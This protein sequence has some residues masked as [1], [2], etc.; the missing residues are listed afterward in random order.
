MPH[1]GVWSW[2]TERSA[3]Q[4]TAMGTWATVLVALGAAIAALGQ[5]REAQ[6][7]RTERAQ[8]QVVALMELDPDDPTSVDL[9]IKNYGPTAARDV[10][11]EVSPTPRR[12]ESSGGAEDVWLPAVI[13]TLAPGQE[14]RTWWDT[15]AARIG[16]EVLRA[17]NRHDVTITFQGARPGKRE[18][19]L[20]VLDWGAYE[21]KLYSERKTLH[22]AAVALERLEETVKRWGEGI[23]GLKV[24]VRSGGAKD[25]RDAERRRERLATRAVS[26]PKVGDLPSGTGGSE[27]KRGRD[28]GDPDIADEG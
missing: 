23:S 1:V 9:V 24:F 6:R 26:L 12:T 19:L 2:I 5:L 10:Q 28:L 22:H 15:S 14:W 8:P 13:P 4:W 21:G 11:I 3:E 16:S 7:L 17:E 25:E 18:T 20:S 27:P